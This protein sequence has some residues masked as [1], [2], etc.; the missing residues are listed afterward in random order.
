AKREITRLK[1]VEEIIALCTANKKQKNNA[2]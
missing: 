2:W 1:R